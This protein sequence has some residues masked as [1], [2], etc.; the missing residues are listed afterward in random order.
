MAAIRRSG[1]SKPKP[2]P[3][4]LRYRIDPTAKK[5]DDLD[6]LEK[7]LE[8]NKLQ[9]DAE[10]YSDLLDILQ[11]QRDA[12]NKKRSK[13]LPDGDVPVNSWLGPRQERTPRKRWSLIKIFWCVAIAFIF[14]KMFMK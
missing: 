5:L 3:P 13:L 9:Y 2:L 6:A 12:A 10:T 7:E 11:L 1:D 8:R 4:P 14:L